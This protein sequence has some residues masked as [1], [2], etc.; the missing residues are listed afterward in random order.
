MIQLKNY[1]ELVLTVQFLMCITIFLDIPIARQ[2]LGFV[3]LS[4]I[5]GAVCLKIIKVRKLDL[6]EFVLLSVGISIA[7]LMF[8]GALINQIYPLFGFSEPLSTLSLIITI[9]IVSSGLL[10]ISFFTDG[11]LSISTSMRLDK[12]FVFSI[13][14][15]LLFPLLSIL[16]ATLVN[17]YMNNSILLLLIMF[18]S[19]FVILI[20]ISKRIPLKLYPIAILAIAIALLFHEELT[21]SYIY[22]YD[23][24][25]EYYL[26]MLVKNSSLWKNVITLATSDI[27]N[28]NAMLSVT[29]LPTVYSN[30]L[31]LSGIWVFKILYPL[32]FSL[33]PLGLYKTCQKQI[34]GKAAFLSVF[35]FMSFYTFYRELLSL[36]RQMIAELF[37]VLLIFLF[38]D[39]KI[40]KLQKRVLVI[41]FTI[42]LVVSHYSTSYV[43]I[44]IISIA[45]VLSLF[46]KKKT[47]ITKGYVILT[48]VMAFFWAIFTSASSL[49]NDIVR[50]GVGRF[51]ALF[52]EFFNPN[53]R[54]ADVLRAIGMGGPAES[55]GHT[56]GR[57]FNYLAEL[58]IMVGF[59]A[60]ILM[61]KRSREEYNFR[62]EY[63]LF[64][65]GGM[66]ML[67]MSIIVP[68]FASALNMTRIYHLMLFFLAPFFIIGGVI[69]FKCPLKILGKW[70]KHVNLT[71][72]VTI[73]LIFYFLFNIGFIYEITG[74]V[75]FSSALSMD[76]IKNT[77]SPVIF[78][79]KYTCGGEVYGAEWLGKNRNS[80]FE[81]YSDA[82]AR[83]H[84]LTSYGMIDPD[85]DRIHVLSNETVDIRE[86]SYIYLRYLNIAYG[87]MVGLEGN[88]WNTSDI[89]SLLENQNMIYSN[90]ECHI[91]KKP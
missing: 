44:F 84:V 88:I 47:Q 49:F 55:F 46:V 66:I 91:Y 51:N 80:S 34:G 67:L 35:F 15:L 4:F 87:K 10:A 90:G 30:F 22:G 83:F 56:I 59:I 3:F 52:A 71:A 70:A 68:Y 11:D 72:L 41:V 9:N 28:Y 64:S 36:G 23:M 21:T 7:F 25:L 2:I 78:Y 89:T 18:I 69:M 40:G 26:F 79:S 48:F 54:Q 65:Y 85:S 6:V 24:H 43:Y 45:W 31:N 13:L 77:S 29:I 19:A 76:R 50:F 37:L 27:A 33:V 53:T 16:G 63:I 82:D 73:V 8:V 62:Q 74:D 32:I 38:L 1:L 12:R 14:L 61:R 39:E 60:I 5:P 81:I 86:E 75:P 20:T 42:G 57:Y 17:C 58:F